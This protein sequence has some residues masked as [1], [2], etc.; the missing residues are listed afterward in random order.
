M[1]RIK[2]VIF[3]GIAF[4]FIGCPA[5]SLSPLFEPKDLLFHPGLI[6]AWGDEEKKDMFIFERSDDK[7][8]TLTVREEDGDTTVYTAQLGKIGKYWFLDSYPGWSKRDY[9]D[10]GT[11]M[12]S[13]IWIEGDTLRTSSLEGD[14]LK[15]LIEK[16]ALK[17]PHAIVDG[18]VILTAT[19]EELQKLVL[20]LAEDK[21]AFPTP[22]GSLV[23]LM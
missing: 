1:D 16:G 10:L 15:E 9:H 20:R 2:Y 3:L 4:V 7:N 11:H 22:E 17:I 6:G 23:R 5:R 18:Q 8:Y 14:R 19:T 12:I 21:K 13:R